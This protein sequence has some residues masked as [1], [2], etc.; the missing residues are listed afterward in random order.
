MT[1]L[2]AFWHR[3]V[4][5][6]SLLIPVLGMLKVNY[7]EALLILLGAQHSAFSA[8]RG[9]TRRLRVVGVLSQT[10]VE[11]LVLDGVPFR[12]LLIDVDGLVLV[13]A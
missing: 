3:R 2:K 5:M 9:S 7:T 12:V 11:L 6:I 10:F 13:L 4:Q 1:T 8:T